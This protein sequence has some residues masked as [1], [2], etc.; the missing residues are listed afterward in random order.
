MKIRINKRNNKNLN[1]KF[2]DSSETFLPTGVSLNGADFDLTVNWDTSYNYIEPQLYPKNVQVF[3]SSNNSLLSSGGTYYVQQASTTYTSA[4]SFVAQF[5]GRS[6][7]SVDVYIKDL[8]SQNVTKTGTIAANGSVSS[9]SGWEISS[10]TKTHPQNANAINGIKIWRN[11]YVS[12]WGSSDTPNNPKVENYSTHENISPTSQPTDGRY[13]IE[14]TG[15]WLADDGN[16]YLSMPKQD[17]KRIW[18]NFLNPFKTVLIKKKRGVLNFSFYGDYLG[19]DSKKN[20]ANI[21][22]VDLELYN[23]KNLTGSDCEIAGTFLANGETISSSFSLGQSNLTFS[24]D[25]VTYGSFAVANY[26]SWFPKACFWNMKTSR[27]RIKGQNPH[28]GTSNLAIEGIHIDNSGNSKFTLHGKGDFAFFRGLRKL[29][30]TGNKFDLSSNELDYTFAGCILMNRSSNLLKK[31]SCKPTSM[32]GVVSGLSA[33]IPKPLNADSWS[34]PEDGNTVPAIHST[35][36]PLHKKP[37]AFGHQ[38]N[39]SELTSLDYAFEGANYHDELSGW[40]QINHAAGDAYN[41]KNLTDN[42]LASLN[43]TFEKS[44]FGG[45]LYGWGKKIHT[46]A[47]VDSMFKDNKSFDNE[48]LKYFKPLSRSG[49]QKMFK[50]SG[51]REEYK[52]AELKSALSSNSSSDDNEDSPDDS[53]SAPVFIPFAIAASEFTPPTS[54]NLPGD[55]LELGRMYN[56]DNIT[57]GGESLKSKYIHFDEDWNTLEVVFR[58]DG[59]VEV[60]YEVFESSTHKMEVATWSE[61]GIYPFSETFHITSSPKVWE[62]AIQSEIDSGLVTVIE[63]GHGAFS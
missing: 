51:L 47:S 39:L 24:C 13:T 52:S 62:N 56:S 60:I 5:I 63:F 10:V 58:D 61:A 59:I 19:I 38:I 9:N 22:V 14:V 32:E 31:L 23:F 33:A 18:N 54:Q 16:R 3:Y 50:N 17:V 35:N 44:S 30:T 42:N 37:A 15:G 26:P 4:T 36:Y 57:I 11:P 8:Y 46:E 20:Y 41:L 28:K 55:I 25:G 53:S 7:G 27:H 40:A 21:K 49:L 1:L 6:D 29:S 45:N 43:G 12:D 2:A 34:K 48:S